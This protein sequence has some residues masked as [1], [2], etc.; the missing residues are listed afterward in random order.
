[1]CFNGRWPGGQPELDVTVTSLRP[2]PGPA[3]AQPGQACAG[4]SDSQ[5]PARL[6]SQPGAHL[7]VGRRAPRPGY[8]PARARDMTVKT[9]SLPGSLAGH[10]A[11]VVSHVTDWTETPP[12]R[13]CPGDSD[14]IIGCPPGPSAYPVIRLVH[15]SG[16]ALRN[17]STES[18]FTVMAMRVQT[19][20]SDSLTR[21]VRY[22]KN[23]HISLC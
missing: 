12:G 8:G 20:T 11:T 21:D 4:D 3:P 17:C 9:G 10:G 15:S 18:P 19:L 16:R 23:L 14:V 6:P 2:G 13:T 22:S 7:T 1:M 5:A